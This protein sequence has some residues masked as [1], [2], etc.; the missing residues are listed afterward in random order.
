MSHMPAPAFLPRAPCRPRASPPCPAPP[1][2]P[3]RTQTR[4]RRACI[5][6]R[7]WAFSISGRKPQRRASATK[8]MA[9]ATRRRSSYRHTIIFLTLVPQT[10]PR[11]LQHVVPPVLQHRGGRA[12][13][14][15]FGRWM[16]GLS[17]GHTLTR[18]EERWRK[19]AFAPTQSPSH[20][21]KTALTLFSRMCRRMAAPSPPPP[22]SSASSSSIALLFLGVGGA[23]CLLGCVGCECVGVRG[24]RGDV[25]DD[26]PPSQPAIQPALA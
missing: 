19:P 14:C 21:F 11:P 17:D 1:P 16:T 20:Q 3:A 25:S 4:L 5:M 9:G 2:S 8:A 15:V 26:D 13:L 7:V 12:D 23:A 24:S 18:R 22:C 10:R 6:R